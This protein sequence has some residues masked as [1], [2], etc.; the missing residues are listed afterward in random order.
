MAHQLWWR[1][2]VQRAKV[3][4]TATGSG[5]A[6]AQ[7]QPSHQIDLDEQVARLVQQKMEELMPPPQVAGIRKHH[8]S[9]DE[10]EWEDIS[11]QPDSRKI[12]RQRFLSFWRNV[13]TRDGWIHQMV[14]AIGGHVKGRLLSK[15][16][17]KGRRRNQRTIGHLRPI[18]L[19]TP[20]P[21]RSLTHHTRESTLR[22][23]K[24][25]LRNARSWDAKRSG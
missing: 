1:D 22:P 18:R 23:V 8:D 4:L 13:N 3:A 15:R 2:A 12:Q 17:R 16:R 19:Q 9:E 24:R 20:L 6:P 5:E 7:T 25:P 10:S 21:L 14:T 11:E